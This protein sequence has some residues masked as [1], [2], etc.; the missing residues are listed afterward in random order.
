MFL[1]TGDTHADFKR[2]S[3]KRF[4]AQKTLTKD[5]YIVVCG[6]FGIWDD[7]AREHYELDQL[8]NRSFTTLFVDGNHSNFEL[9][10]KFP[11]EEWNGGL[12]HRVRPSVIHLMRGQVYTINGKKI[13]TMGGA[14]SHDIKDGILEPDDPDFKMKYK[15]LQR[16]NALFRVN[17]LSWWKEELPSADEYATALRN[18]EAH[19]WQVDYVFTH[20]C[21]NEVLDIISGGL[22][23]RDELTGFLE[24]IKSKLGFKYWYFGH[25]HDNR[26]ILRRF[27]MLYEHIVE[28]P[29]D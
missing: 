19:G 6:D 16:R 27:A 15:Q 9:L 29:G 26:V 1:V 2:F 5:D 20:C 7:S 10:A 8:N 23:Q 4:I 14:Y 3:T 22:Y 11:V 17:H 21:P 24:E 28:I 13:F 18:L 25:Y 12:I